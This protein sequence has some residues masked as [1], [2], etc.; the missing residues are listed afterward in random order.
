MYTPYAIKPV[1][2]GL[3]PRPPSFLYSRAILTRKNWHSEEITITT[4]YSLED[5]KGYKVIRIGNSFCREAD[6]FIKAT[7]RQIAQEQWELKPVFIYC[8]PDT[9]NSE[10]PDLIRNFIVYDSARDVRR[11]TNTP[12]CIDITCLTRRQS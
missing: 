4:S 12:K 9:E 1:I 2:P 8:A 10:I 6:Q 7:G 5:R 3:T 11:I